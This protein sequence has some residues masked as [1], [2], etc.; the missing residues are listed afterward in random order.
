MAEPSA[1]Q[2]PIQSVHQHSPTSDS[3]NWGSQQYH[4]GG[5]R[6]FPDNLDKR[7]A[8]FGA[9]TANHIPLP[10]PSSAQ[11]LTNHLRKWPFAR[12]RELAPNRIPER[13]PTYAEKNHKRHDI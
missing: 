13:L 11:K 3:G 6:E 8:R 5:S 1:G 10:T 7:N 4:G 2:I 12:L 9:L